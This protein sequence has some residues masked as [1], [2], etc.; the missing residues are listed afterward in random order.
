MSIIGTEITQ[1]GN[2]LYI[3][4]LTPTVGVIALTSFTDDTDGEDLINFFIKSFRYSL[5]GGIVWSEWSSLINANIT[6]IIVDKYNELVFEYRYGMTGPDISGLIFNSVQI[7]ATYTTLLPGPYFIRSVFN[8]FFDSNDSEVLGWYC[9]VIEKLFNQDILARYISRYNDNGSPD[10]FILF[11]KFVSKFIAYYVILARR[12]TEFYTDDDFV[13]EFLEGRGLITTPN[14]NNGELNY[15]MSTY[16]YQIKNRGTIKILDRRIPERDYQTANTIDGEL[17]RSFYF[18]DGDEFL[19]NL[20]RTQDLGWN[21]GS[22]SPLYMGLENNENINKIYEPN[23]AITNLSWWPTAGTVAIQSVSGIANLKITTSGGIGS[24]SDNLKY[25]TIDPKI[26]YV[27]DFWVNKAAG[28]NLSV[29]MNG[30]DYS[31][32]PINLTSAKTGVVDNF[33]IQNTDLARHDGHYQHI[34]CILYNHTHGFSASDKLNINAGN[35]LIVD[36]GVSKIIPLILFS[37]SSGNTCFIQ[38]ISFKPLSTNY[39][40]GFIQTQNFISCWIKDNRKRFDYIDLEPVSSYSLQQQKSLQILP[41][42]ELTET[43]KRYLIPYNAH[44]ILTSINDIVADQTT[45]TTTTTTTTSTTTTTTTVPTTTTTTSTTT[46]TTTPAT[47][48]TTTSTTTTTTTEHIPSPGESGYFT[49]YAQYQ[50]S[51]LSI[52]GNATCPPEFASN[53]VAPGDIEYKLITTNITPQTFSVILDGT[54]ISGPIHTHIG[55]FVNGISV[56]SQNVSG[57]GSYSLVLGSA[58]TSTD[59]LEIAIYLA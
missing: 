53:T 59:S 58:V 18:Q 30:F 7:N 9:N 22:S 54:I 46:T 5:N 11:W 55:L 17:L 44:I 6:S 27:F 42:R 29:G 20:Y 13:R 56:S 40:R 39:S 52:T 36:S 14:N 4:T 35:N 37:G 15:L 10:D 31:G 28:T 41:L 49:G 25:I 1:E 34:Q 38:K 45:T 48:T 21:I 43:I 8:K 24:T 3:K 26:N 2:I 32:T 50:M 33:F 23:N 51:I 19:F 16:L 47:T 57:S 12:L